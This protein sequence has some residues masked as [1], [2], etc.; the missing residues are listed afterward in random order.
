MDEK[1]IN[2]F[3]GSILHDIGKLVQRGT[4]QKVRHSRIGA[5]FLQQYTDNRM[6][7]N[8]LRYHH[9]QE[10]KSAQLEKDDLSYITYIADNIA[11]GVD[12]REHEGEVSRKWNSKT[13]LEDIF[14]RFGQ[15]SENRYFQ[16]KELDLSVDK[17][18]ADTHNIEFSAGQYSGI[19]RRIEDTL[20][21]TEFTEEYMQSILNLL[22]ATASFIPSSTNMKEVVDISLYDHLKMTSG[23]A[24][25][26]FHYLEEKEETDYQTK[27]FVNGPQFYEEEAFLLTS[28]DISG[29]QDFIYTITS[30][31]AHKQLRSRSFYLDM[32]SEWIVDSLLK[33]TQLTRANLMYSGGGHAYLILPNTVN[34]KK[35]IDT[36]EE[37]FNSFFLSNY[38]TKLYVALG[39]TPFS[40]KE[41]MKGNTPETYRSIFQ[42]VS[43]SIGEKKVTRYS[44]GILLKLNK[45]GKRAGRECAICH[46]VDQL[47]EHENKCQLCYKLE[48]FSK[49]IQRDA[50]FKVDDDENGLPIGPNAY[51]HKSSVEEIK[52][53]KTSKQIYA[54]NQ[55]YTGMNQATR[56]WVADYTSSKYNDFSQYALREWTNEDGTVVKGIKRIGVLRCD[57][58]D[59][60]YAFMAG[61]SEQDEG[62]YNT[63]T[64]TAAFSRSMSL[65]FK[66]YIN[67]FA[68]D[69]HLTIIYAGGDDVFL[70][71]A[72][73]DVVAFS[74]EF[75]ELFLR[76]TNGKL[77][78]STGI[79]LFP[80][81][82]PVNIMAR[83]T[84]ELEESAKNNGKD[85][86]SLFSADYTF[87]YDVFIEDIY[88]NKLHVIRTFFDQESERGKAFLYKLLDLIR[89][90]DEKDRISFARLA[91][92]L[93]RL[94]ESS[95]NQKEFARFKHQMR[96]WFDDSEQI[97]RAEMALLLY[98]Y[99][100]RK[101]E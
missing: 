100:T 40:A 11:S 91:Y 63:F 17:I 14:N 2:L 51:L 55:F 24:A 64:R 44:P 87:T 50:F 61:F 39:A 85:S 43:K 80:D 60:G 21:V 33:E 47:L 46:N 72:W 13:N 75:R 98:V 74:I 90:R 36:I 18:F 9:Y 37:R 27:L 84:G 29:I 19:L 30:S 15:K 78:L 89:T 59:L 58:D 53:Q 62:T 4:Q 54:K 52:T 65:F 35:A 10:I 97:R 42:R 71:G 23:F 3:Y 99:E 8:Q 25:A 6:I 86:I 56:L 68:E 94:E 82:T 41:V 32:I 31:G 49:T 83:L 1:L 76:W 26:V 34:A 38:S 28:F 66:L 81:K 45:G 67:A 69:K 7:L 73:D 92:Y 22:E 88:K 12:R 79:G 16:P 20:K 57:V 70:L 5:D 48:Q 96:E 93:A 95:K 101:D 77:T